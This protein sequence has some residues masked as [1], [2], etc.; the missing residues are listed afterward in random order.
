[1]SYLLSA[2]GFLENEFFYAP[3]SR[4]GLS[5]MLRGTGMVFHRDILLSHAWK[6]G[7]IVEDTEYTYQLL[8]E[9]RQFGSLPM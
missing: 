8:E 2:A 6:A 4:L 5:V 9:G 3:K 7:S 1:M